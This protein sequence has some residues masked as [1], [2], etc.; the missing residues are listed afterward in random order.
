MQPVSDVFD[1]VAV[2]SICGRYVI[3]LTD[4]LTKGRK[5]AQ[6]KFPQ[7]RETRRDMELTEIVANDEGVVFN[8]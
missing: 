6:V 8:F 3:D 2:D 5:W 1:I 7:L 4:V